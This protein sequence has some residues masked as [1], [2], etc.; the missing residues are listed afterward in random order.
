MLQVLIAEDEALIRQGLIQS[1]QWDKLGLT[2]AGEA[3]NGEQ[4]LAIMRERPVDIVLTDMKMPVCDGKAMLQ[5]MEKCGYDCEVIVLSEYTDFAYMQQAIHAHVF[6]YLLKPVESSEL[7]ALFSRAADKFRQKKASDSARKDP[8][9]ELFSA[10]LLS[11]NAAELAVSAFLGSHADSGCMVGKLFFR[12]EYSLTGISST[13]RETGEIEMHILPFS[14]NIIAVLAL[15]NKTPARAEFILQAKLRELCDRSGADQYRAGISQYKSSVA[16]LPQAV[17]EASAAISFVCP[18]KKIVDYRSVKALV[19]AQ[20]PPPVNE[21]QLAA[22]LSSG[23]D[24]RSEISSMFL[25]ALNS[26]DYLY[27]PAARRMLMEFSLSLERCCQET[28]RGVNISQLIGGSYLD[29][30]NRI[31]WQEDLNRAFDLILSR[32]CSALADMR[33]GTTEDV[34]RRVLSAVQ[35]RYMDDLSLINF[36]QEYHINYIYLSKKFKEMTGE[37]FTNY[38]MQVRMNKARQLIE[39]DGLSE[40]QTASLVGYTN[41]YYFISSYKKYFGTEDTKDEK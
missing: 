40:K 34:L 35:T 17:K 13:H 32:T 30:I 22:L 37:T 21:K 38:L 3:E 23:S 25:S 33:T 18:G 39:Q 26:H 4:A 29:L 36:A 9:S 27:M 12:G 31:E 16:M 41:P 14:G 10:A 11:P 7:N 19:S 15:S 1:I 24:V 8:I 2:L 5:E 28:G 6:D 20:Y